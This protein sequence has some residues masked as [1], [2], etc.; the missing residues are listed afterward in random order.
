M[1]ITHGSKEADKQRVGSRELR[2]LSNLSKVDCQEGNVV[3]LLN[4][5]SM[6]WMGNK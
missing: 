3:L 2:Q 1:K 5:P 6:Y 4:M